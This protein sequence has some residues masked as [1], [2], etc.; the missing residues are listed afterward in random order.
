MPKISQECIEEA[1]KAL[2]HFDRD[3]LENYLK[4]VFLK[5]KEYESLTGQAAIER[6]MKEVN[7][8]EMELFFQDATIK[9][10]NTLAFELNAEPIKAKKADVRGVMAARKLRG[11]VKDGD[12]RKRNIPDA[13]K[14][15]FEKIVKRGVSDLTHEELS[16]WTEDINS[17]TIADVVDGKETKDPAIRKIAD[18]IKDYFEYIKTQLILS[19]AMRTDEFAEG[20]YFGAVHDA[21]KIINGGKSWTQMALSKITGKFNLAENKTR[22]KNAL[23]KRIDVYKTFK[24]TN[25]VD[26]DGNIDME[27]VHKIL[28]RIYD[29]I[30]TQKSEIFTRSE[31]ANDR[32]AVAKKSKMFFV[33]KSLRDQYEY[34]KEYGRGNLF[35]MYMRD[36]QANAARIGRTK[37]WGDNP[38]SM[39]NDLRKVQQDVDPKDTTWWEHTDYYF[40]S[41]MGLDRL[42]TAPNIS[43]FFS[44][45]RTLTTMARLPFI[46]I[47]SVSDIGYVSSFATRFGVN[48][49]KAWNYHL[50]HLY[51]AFPD[52]ERKYIAKLMKTQV[53]SQLGFMGRWSE[54]FNTT[55]FLNKISTKFFKLNLL[56]NFDQGNK[57]GNM[58]LMAKAFAENSNK[59]FDAL[60]QQ[61]RK[62]LSRF[63]DANEWDL[64]RKKNQN[65]LFTT[66]NVDA[67]TK[68]EIHAHWKTTDQK[69]PL[70]D[71][72]DDLWRRVYGMFTTT[73]ENTV[74][75]PSDFERAFL[76][77]GTTPGSVNGI[78]LRTFTQFKMYT[79]AYI[80]RVLIDGWRN[81]DTVQAKLMWATSM[82]M[83]TLPLSFAS[84]FLKYR[85]MGLTMPDPSEMNIAQRE[86]FLLSLLA[87]SLGIFTGFLNSNRQNS[88]M[89]LSLLGSPSVSFIGNSMATAAA[90]ISG[91]P[92]RAA[93]NLKN[94]ANYFL[95]LQ[96]MPIL[97]PLL[98]EAMGEEAYL[99]PGQQH[100]F[101][102]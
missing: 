101:G 75:A 91:D 85:L 46:G 12:Y 39:Y 35:H 50:T 96:T 92:M 60:P 69:L 80:D 2:K 66:D 44:N 47:D 53:D 24:K 31:V 7:R 73:V 56:E 88:Q 3:E 95:P 19:G 99:E 32:E 16:T 41:V 89:A 74:L 40:K 28:D 1:F 79:L 61:M 13:V 93:K 15:E 37:M 25:A 63:I 77:R 14:A 90:L 98:N 11:K 26:M 20:R 48:Y 87:P 72:K 49:F 64:L 54:N 38:Y 27:Q 78:L 62:Y 23:L 34:N 45:I 86:K 33:W 9:A 4:D 71:M 42:N 76:H 8:E 17:D 82:L 94:T 67:L 5:A 55:D 10:K 70:S 6:S 30:T 97:T 57:I 83:G 58:H 36:A 100:I 18:K 59:S 51:N 102:Q 29:N 84:M 52:A 81:A 21:Q 22:W 65:G 43:N 68:D